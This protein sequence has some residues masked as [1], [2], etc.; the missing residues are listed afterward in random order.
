[1]R[2]ENSQNSHLLLEKSE[3]FYFLSKETNL[4][5][6]LFGPFHTVVETFENRTWVG[7]FSTQQSGQL[8]PAG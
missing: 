4:A 1:M 3:I 7:Y 6:T 8:R 2:T 5:N